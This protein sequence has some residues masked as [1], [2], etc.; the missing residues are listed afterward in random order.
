MQHL[1]ADDKMPARRGWQAL[2]LA[3]LMVFPVSR[4]AAVPRAPPVAAA[5]DAAQARRL[6]V[7]YQCGSCHTIEGVE[8]AAGTRAPPLK[9]FG[10]R[11]YI[12]GTLPNTGDVLERWIIDPPSLLPGTPMPALGVSVADAQTIAAYLR[13]QP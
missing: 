1:P 12:A 3:A 9:G 10:R 11:S 7:Q 8:H 2:L 13:D 5:A 6:L 4:E